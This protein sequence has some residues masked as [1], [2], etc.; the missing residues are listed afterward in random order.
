VVVIEFGFDHNH[1]HDCD[2]DCDHD[3]RRRRDARRAPGG[4]RRFPAL[5]GSQK[6][7]WWTLPGLV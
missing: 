3:L 7:R 2:H 4:A 6:I 1:D 5:T